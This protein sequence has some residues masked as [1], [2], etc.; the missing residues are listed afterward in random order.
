MLYMQVNNDCMNH[1]SNCIITNV[2]HINRGE[3]PAVRINSAED[4]V[5]V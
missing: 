3:T 4:C 1:F 2:Y 5:T